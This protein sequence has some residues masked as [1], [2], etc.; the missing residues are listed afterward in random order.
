MEKEIEKDPEALEKLSKEIKEEKPI[1]PQPA[2]Q[3]E[4]SLAEQL[5][6]QNEEKS[7]IW[8]L[9]KKNLFKKNM[10]KNIFQ[11]IGV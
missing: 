6:D 4:K 8:I 3:K 1:K 2:P 9:N 7:Q 10:K 5:Y 11:R